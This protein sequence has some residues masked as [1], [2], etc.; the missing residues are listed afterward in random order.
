MKIVKL[1]IM[2]VSLGAIFAFLYF[3]WRLTIV[4]ALIALATL[5]LSWIFQ[6]AMHEVGHFFFGRLSGY[7]LVVL[8]Y[9]RFNF[10]CNRRGDFSI[11]VR[12]TK[13]GQCIML[14]PDKMPVR[15]VAYNLGGILFNVI[16]ALASGALL[17]LNKP[18][19]TLLFI[20]LFMMG[21]YKAC[22][23][24]IPSSKGAALTDGYVLKLLRKKPAVQYD[25][26]R[27]LA[28]YSAMFWDEEIDAAEF[29]Y[30]REHTDREEEL[31]YYNEIQDIL[32]EL[33]EEHI[34]EQK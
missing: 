20:E 5:C 1:S 9:S 13:G 21:V 15:Y 10:M 3:G 24:A 34:S 31:I 26:A 33:S 25:Y 29:T 8:Q 30:D 12:K 14:P 16:I 18:F 22:A 4:T 19:F 23:N 17:L 7:K 27:Y 2:L 32:R 28:L 6:G 11:A